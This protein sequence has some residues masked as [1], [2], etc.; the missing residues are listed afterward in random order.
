[1][2]KKAILLVRVS[3]QRQDFD[4][5]EKQLYYLAIA[6]GYKDNEIIAIAEKESG[7]KLSEEERKGLNRLKEE[8]SNGGVKCVYVWEVSR[9]G[10]KKKVIFSVVELLQTH[11]IQLIV[12]EPFIK[13]LNSDGS[14]NEGAETI[15]TLYAQM[16]ES[17]MRNK[18]SRWARTKK[19]NSLKGK[20]NGGP[21]VKY[22][23]ALDKDNY[24]IVN[25]NEA[26]IVRTIYRLYAEDGYS[27]NA[28]V[29][30]LGSRGIIMGGFKVRSILNDIGYTG[31]EYVTTVFR[32]G[33]RAKGQ[34]IK[35]PQII[36]KE[37]FE[38]VRQ[39]RA[40]ANKVVTR[41]E[42]YYFGRQLIKCP[43]CEHGYIGYKDIAVY[44]CVAYKHTNHDIPKC[45]NNNIINI[46]ILDTLLWHDAKGEYISYITDARKVDRNTYN[47]QINVLVQKI[48]NCNSIIQTASS[49][50]EKIGDMYV[51]GVYTKDKFL[52]EINKVKTSTKEAE[53]D[54]IKYNGDIEKIKAL[55]QNIDNE[56]V[57]D[58]YINSLAIA[59]NIDSYKEMYEIV[60]KFITNVDVENCEAFEGA[61]NVHKKGV[62]KK[63]TVT[64]LDG[65]KAVYIA[66]YYGKLKR[67][68]NIPK[69]VNITKDEAIAIGKYYLNITDDVQYIDREIGR[70]KRK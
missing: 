69:L 32:D 2:T 17:E 67:F 19:A 44:C 27:Y 28:I 29:K 11:G 26:E 45:H 9:I 56:D 4:E 46:N 22:G 13:L 15:L 58:N 41:G 16:A 57:T 63:V 21:T 62:W 51:S 47:E 35:Y 5:Q 40:K 7:I 64:H 30:E 36:S 55:L 52:N 8:I 24:Y 43:V 37:I 49:K 48:N 39:K 42:S 20:W 61:E 18:L 66:N 53:N 10:R 1:M 25:E 33:K 68:Y 65:H 34:V 31:E 59:D 14:I 3:T 6:D 12:K 23:Y 54:K 38:Q 50:L 70:R 60:H